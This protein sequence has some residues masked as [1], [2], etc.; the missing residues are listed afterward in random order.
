MEDKAMKY[1][2]AIMGVAIIGYMLTS[3]IAEAAPPEPSYCCP[4]CDV[5]FYTYDELYQHFTTEHPSE[6]IDIVWS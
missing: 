5:C 1:M 4:I 2:V 3:V 6:P